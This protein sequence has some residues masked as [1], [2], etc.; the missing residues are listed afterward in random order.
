MTMPESAKTIL[1]V[2]DEAP[3]RAYLTGIL[4]ADGYGVLEAADYDEALAMY[5]QHQGEVG[6][7]LIDVSLP[8][9]NGFELA[10]TMLAIEPKLKV[11]FISGHVGTELC[12]FY[13]IP[14]TD[15]HFLQ[16]P[17]Q[18]MELLQRVRFV[19]Q[20]GRPASDSASA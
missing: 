4:R 5:Q 15:V 9:K 18:P 7:L 11:L 8:G 3:V 13:D 17:F 14:P 20:L 16:K 2:D 12:R 19:S 1:L 10:R 6:L